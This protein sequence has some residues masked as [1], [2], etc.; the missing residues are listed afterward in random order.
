MRNLGLSL[1]TVVVSAC[2]PIADH[3]PR[4]AGTDAS[5]TDAGP[6]DAGFDAGPQGPLVLNP[7]AACNK[8][9]DCEGPEATCQTTVSM[10]AFGGMG[11]MGGGANTITFPD[12]YC[13]AT[14]TSMAQCAA[15]SECG[16][17]K[18]IDTL[19]PFLMG[20]MI[21][22]GVLDQIPSQCLDSCAGSSQCREG[23]VCQS[24]IEAAGQAQRLP[25]GTAFLFSKYCL[26]PFTPPAV[27][28]GVSP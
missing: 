23:Y 24:L 11:G 17:K 28:A 15:G 27:D 21:P 2:N 1:M 18:L 4:D 8:D 5:L 25:P 20:M 6:L 13:T 26:P 9:Q 16:V 22:P 7:G 3:L 14:C 12:G 19:E 10:P